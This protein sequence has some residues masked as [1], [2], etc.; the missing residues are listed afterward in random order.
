MEKKNVTEQDIKTQIENLRKLDEL[1]AKLQD[2]KIEFEVKGQDYRVRLLNSK[3]I[4][5]KDNEKLRYY[6][7]LVN[8]GDFKHE[9]VLIENYKKQGIDIEEME[10]KMKELD[11]EQEALELQLGQFLK[12]NK[13]EALCKEL[14]EKIKEV[15]QKKLMIAMTKDLRMSISLENQLIT[16]MIFYVTYQMLEKK[17]KENNE[18]KWIKCFDTFEDFD[19]N[20]DEELKNQAG[21]GAML[22]YRDI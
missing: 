17:V 7:R 1:K 18:E 20:E 3:E 11:K 21:M 8:E 4:K 22:L 10:E 13:N 2:N 19:N 16:H 12:E 15:M 5:Q 6:S 14:H 9:K